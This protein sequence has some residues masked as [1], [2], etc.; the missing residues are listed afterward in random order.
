[1]ESIVFDPASEW[2]ELDVN[3]EYMVSTHGV[4]FDTKTNREVPLCM[5]RTR[6]VENWC[7]YVREN[8]PG[9]RGSTRGIVAARSVLMSF[10]GPPETSDSSNRR[11]GFVV[12]ADGDKR[13]IAL[14]NLSWR[15]PAVKW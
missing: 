2:I 5:I 8:R 3:P 10:V 13:N 15:V 9:R 6:D 1:M 14:S 11:A 4:L 12:Y 7:W